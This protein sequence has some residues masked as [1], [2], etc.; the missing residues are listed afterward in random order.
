[1]HKTRKKIPT[2]D[3]MAPLVRITERKVIRSLRIRSGQWLISR[4]KWEF[5]IYSNMISLVNSGTF[6][7]ACQDSPWRGGGSDPPMDDSPIFSL[8]FWNPRKLGKIWGMGGASKYVND[9]KNPSK[10]TLQIFLKLMAG[11]V[12][13]SNIYLAVGTICLK[14]ITPNVFSQSNNVH[15]N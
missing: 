8:I 3:D 4:K 10:G 13:D 5:I 9:T 1:M 2:T 11:F 14:I 12:L 15:C 6:K 7:G